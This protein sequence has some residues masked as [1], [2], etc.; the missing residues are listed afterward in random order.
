MLLPLGKFLIC[1]T[2]E[3]LGAH[4]KR[5]NILKEAKSELEK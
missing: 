5:E 1:G 3:N 2:A 4:K